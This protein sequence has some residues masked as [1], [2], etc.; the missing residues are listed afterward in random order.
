MKGLRFILGL[1]SFFLKFIPGYAKL[2]R[3]LQ[4]KLNKNQNFVWGAEDETDLNNLEC[5]LLS[6][7]CLAFPDASKPYDIYTDASVHAIGASVMQDGCLVG[8]YFR[9]FSKADEK[10]STTEKEGLAIFTGLKQFRHLLLGAECT[11]HTDQK[12]WCSLPAVKDPTGRIA[13]WILFISEFDLKIKYIKGEQ[14]V[15]ADY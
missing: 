15:V 2:V 5:V 12:S 10:Y 4:G 8:C 13:R 6:S 3:N 7:G 1:T 14:N 9:V 11:L